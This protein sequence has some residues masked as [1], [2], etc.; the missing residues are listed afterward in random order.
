MLYCD[1][2]RIEECGGDISESYEYNLPRAYTQDSGMLRRLY[3]SE[4]R[5]KGDHIADLKRILT[6]CGRIN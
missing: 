1:A 6:L 3:C 4:K 5:A 2:L